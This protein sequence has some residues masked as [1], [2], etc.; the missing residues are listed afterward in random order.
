M[1]KE[2][3]KLKPVITGLLAQFPETRDND[4]LLT[5]YI[6]EIQLIGSKDFEKFQ[7]AYRDGSLVSPP[8]VTR[9]RALVQL[10]NPNLRGK[11]Y[12]KRKGLGRDVSK[13]INLV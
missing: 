5:S 8:S 2:F 13:E 10:R 9:V 6:W 12:K 11:M 4:R 7:N 3:K 1:I